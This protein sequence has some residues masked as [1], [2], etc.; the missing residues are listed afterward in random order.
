MLPTLTI[1]PEQR[2]ARTPPP[3]F[4]VHGAT[5][6]RKHGCLL[7]HGVF[8]PEFI[9]TLRDT[10]LARN[11]PLQRAQNPHETG[12]VGNRRFMRPLDL[13]GPFVSPDLLANPFAFP[14][15]RA[16]VGEELVL[17][18]CGTV[19][20]LPG[21]T[22]QHIHRDCPPLFNKVVNR[23][24]PAHAVNLF[25]PL[26]EFNASTGTT[27]LFPGTHIDTDTAPADAA[28]IDPVI[29]VGSC[30]LVDGRLYHQGR[31]NRS[32][33]ERPLLFFIF[34]QPWFKDYKNHPRLPCLRISDAE[35]ARLP[36]EHRR[37]LEWTEHY[38]HGL[39]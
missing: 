25:V 26:V 12:E 14:I 21:A 27:R 11:E 9:A 31:P 24:V 15:L 18:V 30:L 5:A 2:A 37:L 19:T 8:S 6:L 29:P 22:E 23:M 33:L 10:A 35:Y 16:V 1:T 13:A 38:R 34:Q 36:E 20:S 39:Y 17:G 3:E 32:D 4:V 28:F 7:L